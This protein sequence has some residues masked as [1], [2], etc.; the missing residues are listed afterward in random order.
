MRLHDVGLPSDQLPGLFESVE[1]GGGKGRMFAHPL[2]QMKKQGR[3]IGGFGRPHRL[4]QLCVKSIGET[5]CT[6]AEA[7]ACELLPGRARTRQEYV[8][9]GGIEWLSGELVEHRT[10]A[11]V[12]LDLR[13]L[14]SAMARLKQVSRG[15]PQAG[16]FDL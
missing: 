8:R 2:G 12:R 1:N 13:N 3:N 7:P 11:L 4:M 9:S 14:S 15:F 6:M 5:S 10:R 16:A